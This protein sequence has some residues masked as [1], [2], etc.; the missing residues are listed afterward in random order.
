MLMIDRELTPA[1]ITQLAQFYKGRGAG[2]L[3]V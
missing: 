3:L 2:D 1:E